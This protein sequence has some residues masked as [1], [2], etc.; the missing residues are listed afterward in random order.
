MAFARFDLDQL[1]FENVEAGC[2][3]FQVVLARREWP[4]LVNAQELLVALVMTPLAFFT[5][6][7]A[8]TTRLSSWSVTEPLSEP[9]AC[10]AATG[11]ARARG[12]LRNAET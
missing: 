10:W 8:P 4:E 3:D 11:T 5:V 1:L 2:D 9:V 12:G 7:V 6:T